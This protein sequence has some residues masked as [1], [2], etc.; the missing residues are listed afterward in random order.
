MFPYLI[1]VALV[2][3]F[4]TVTTL[5]TESSE[6]PLPRI[7]TRDGMFVMA[8]TSEPFIPRGFHYVRIRNNSKH[9]VH[10]PGFYQPLAVEEMFADLAKH[11]FNIVRTFL[12]FDGLFDEHG[13]SE[14]F[15]DNLFDL[16]CRARHHGIYVILERRYVQPVGAYGAAHPPLI[17]ATRCAPSHWRNPAFPML[18]FTFTLKALKHL[19]YTWRILSLIACKQYAQHLGSQYLWESLAR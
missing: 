7:T 3:A 1:N 16:L 12:G 5:Y 14:A 18:T 2:S 11:G 15:L 17:R 9:Y 13:I 19:I 10:T 4:A 8:D 6:R